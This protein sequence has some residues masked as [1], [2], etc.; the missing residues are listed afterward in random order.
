MRRQCNVDAMS[1][2]QVCTPYAGVNTTAAL[3][4]SVGAMVVG[5]ATTVC[6]VVIV[7]DKLAARHTAIVFADHI[8][9]SIAP[10]PLP[11]AHG[12]NLC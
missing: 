9:I 3:I 1:M 10:S 7:Y 12:H 2:Q 11:L 6:L 5:S 4:C 8:V